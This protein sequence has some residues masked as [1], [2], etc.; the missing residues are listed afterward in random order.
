MPDTQSSD[1]QSD[2]EHDADD[3]YGLHPD[4]IREP[5]TDLNGR[6]LF[7]GPGLVLVVLG[8]VSLVY[9]SGPRR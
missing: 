8:M 7:L 4:A 9:R 5:P 1:Q 6:L 3:P 2:T